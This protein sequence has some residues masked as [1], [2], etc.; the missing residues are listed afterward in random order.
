MTETG[1]F[2]AAAVAPP[3]GDAAAVPSHGARRLLDAAVTRT[4]AALAHDL[5]NAL[6]V[7]SMQ[8]EAIAARAGAP[9]GDLFAIAGHASVAADHIERL[10]A[11]TN[12]LIDFARGRLSSDLAVIVAEAVA[13]VPMRAITLSSP[14]VASV[15][16]DPLL[17]RA[18]TLELLVFAL[19]APAVPG[20]RVMTDAEGTTVEVAMGQTCAQDETVEWVVQFIA[21]GGRIEPTADGI[22]LRFPPIA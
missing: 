2:E 7:V 19:R 15:G 18:V 13:L 3:H 21:V 17:T 12:A 22:R 14:P 5:R 16:L 6:G 20:F 9:A 1:A 10:A 4:I 8:V 11:M